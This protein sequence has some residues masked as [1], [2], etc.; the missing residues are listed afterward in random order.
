MLVLPALFVFLFGELLYAAIFAALA[1]TCFFLGR[2]ADFKAI[3]LDF[4]EALVVT[5]AAGCNMKKL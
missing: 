2:N 4:Q 5:A 3:V 1:L